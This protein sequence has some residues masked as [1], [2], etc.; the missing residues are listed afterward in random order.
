M[1]LPENAGAIL[2]ARMSGYVSRNPLL[3]IFTGKRYERYSPVVYANPGRDYDWRFALGLTGYVIW[4]SALEGFERQ[5]GALCRKLKQ[6]VEYYYVDR[7]VGGSTWLLPR[8]DDVDAVLQGKIDSRRMH[9]DLDDLPWMDFQNKDMTQ[10]LKE[11]D[12]GNDQRFC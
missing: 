7:A 6:P 1:N 8:S 4:D 2:K 10:F 9:W 11:A 3:I 12:L 5:M